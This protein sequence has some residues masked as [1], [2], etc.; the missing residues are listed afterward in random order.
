M[1]Q[2]HSQNRRSDHKIC[3]VY[4]RFSGVLFCYE[5]AVVYRLLRFLFCLFVV[6]ML[7]FIAVFVLVLVSCRINV[8][9]S[10]VLGI[11]AYKLHMSG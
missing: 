10:R 4:V 9:P 5:S 6:V 7:T 8:N 11:I 2:K 3:Q 1:E